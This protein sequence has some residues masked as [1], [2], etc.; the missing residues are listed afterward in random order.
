MKS[1]T[2]A[3]ARQYIF[4]GIKAV[5][6]SDDIPGFDWAWTQN[7]GE[8]YRNDDKLQP[9]KAYGMVAAVRRAVNMRAN[10]IMDCPRHFYTRTARR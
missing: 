2:T 6:L 3:R 4:D 7:M 9:R 5:P 1:R 10:A 8:A